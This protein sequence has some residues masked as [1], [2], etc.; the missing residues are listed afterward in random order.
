MIKSIK[1]NQQP[2]LQKNRKASKQ[3]FDSG[4][5]KNRKADLPIT[6]LV[7][8]VFVICI[9]ALL[10]FYSSKLI[11]E[12]LFVGINSMENIASKINEY[13]FY[14]NLEINGE[15]IK[16]IIDI[17]EDRQGKYIEIEEKNEGKDFIIFKTPEKLLFSARYNFPD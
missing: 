4:I 7:I 9:F 15:E 3:F 12:E 6:I 5:L 1:K 8:G 14:K 17:K 16:Q 13:S 10:S 11:F 2:H